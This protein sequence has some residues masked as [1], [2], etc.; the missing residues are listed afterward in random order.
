MRRDS[1]LLVCVA[2][3]A[4]SLLPAPAQALFAQTTHGNCA[5]GTG[6]IRDSNPGAFSV[7]T[8]TVSLEGCE[9]LFGYP[10]RDGMV[11]GFKTDRTRPAAGGCPCS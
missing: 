5:T 3:V 11:R 7:V 4:L 2:L 10:N 1:V 9:R 8:P 6:G